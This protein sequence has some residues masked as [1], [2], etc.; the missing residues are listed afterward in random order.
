MTLGITSEYFEVLEATQIAEDFTG[1]VEDHIALTGNIQ[2]E[3]G[4][5]LWYTA[6]LAHFGGF[7]FKSSEKFPIMEMPTVIERINSLVKAGFVY[8]R[9][10]DQPDKTKQTPNQQ[11]QWCIDNIILWAIKKFPFNIEDTM[12]KNIEKLKARFPDKYSDEAANNR[13]EGDQ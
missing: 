2:S 12:Y 10:F 6:G 8:N 9:D 7:E 1:L 5:V 3:L 13:K 11:L 4:D